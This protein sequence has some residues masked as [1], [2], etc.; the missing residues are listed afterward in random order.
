MTGQTM[1]VSLYHTTF[2]ICPLHLI[3]LKEKV[4]T[5][6]YSS[7]LTPRWAG[8]VSSIEVKEGISPLGGI[9]IVPTDIIC[10]RGW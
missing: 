6:E 2:N 9:V 8:M 3:T 10:L 7:N 4:N 1:S 5:T